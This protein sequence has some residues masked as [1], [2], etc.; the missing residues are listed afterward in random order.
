M[1]GIFADIVVVQD[2]PFQGFDE[3]YLRKLARYT[4]TLEIFTKPDPNV[5]WRRL[6]TRVRSRFG[7][8][9]MLGD[10]RDVPESLVRYLESTY[11][12]RGY[13]VV[14]AC[15]AHLGGTLRAFPR[16]TEK[17]LDLERI[18]SE[19]HRDHVRAGR[20]DAL[21]RFANEEREL[22]L[23]CLANSVVVTSQRDA[24][25]L[26]E[27]GFRND[28]LLFPPQGVVGF[29]TPV[30]PEEETLEAPVRPPTILC[31]GSETTANLDGLRWFRRQVF[32]RIQEAVPSCRLRLIGE[33]ARHIEPGP[34]IDRIG[35]VDVMEPEFRSAAVVALPL[36]MGAGL[37]RR[38][39]EALVRGKTLVTTPTGAQGLFLRPGL[40]AVVLGSEEELARET[41]RVLNDD[42]VRRAYEAQ[43]ALFSRLHLDSLRGSFMLARHLGLPPR[44]ARRVSAREPAQTAT[45]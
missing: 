41:A 22:E 14:I 33:S 20:S 27:R 12:V 32:P 15:G 3:Q 21:A 5:W 17:L 8:P 29:V 28:A 4:S 26:R 6:A 10:S 2:E 31:T 44:S 18:Q 34:G 36:R 9:P 16:T 25:S 40:D 24:T 19:A 23:I 39:V 38:A 13:S 7:A 43:A 45:R 42:A 37:R 11:S 35:W 1:R 30:S